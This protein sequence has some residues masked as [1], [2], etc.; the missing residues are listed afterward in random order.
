MKTSVLKISIFAFIC[1][2]SFNKVRSQSS[3]TAYWYKLQMSDSL[4]VWTKFPGQKLV[5]KDR[6]EYSTNIIVYNKCTGH[7][8]TTG[9]FLVEIHN[10]GPKDF[11]AYVMVQPITSGLMYSPNN[12]VRVSLKPGQKVS[13]YLELR[14]CLPKGRKGMDDLQ[15]CAAC[16]PKLVFYELNVL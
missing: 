9:K 1:I 4:D 16:E 13:N 15:I 12:S 14:V 3:Q 10:N 2:L 6:K 5:L 11:V 7:R 8:G